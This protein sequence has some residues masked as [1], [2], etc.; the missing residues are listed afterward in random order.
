LTRQT[1]N[2]SVL[3]AV[4][5]SRKLHRLWVTAPSNPKAFSSWLRHFVSSAR[6]AYWF[7]TDAGHL[8]GM[9]CISEIVRG[10]FQSGYLGY[11]AFVPHNG[12]GY[13]TLGL[14]AV[15]ADAFRKR[16]F[17]RLEANIQ[18]GNEASRRLV[19]RL[20]FRQEGFSPRY[21]K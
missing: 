15:L 8:A 14:N 20:G 13:M 10:N 6:I 7:R 9:I 18:P 11:Y 5:R 1:P 2:F 12:L 16:R 4:K 21:L 17:H 3:A 19:Q